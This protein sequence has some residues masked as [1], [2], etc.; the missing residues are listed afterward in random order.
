MTTPPQEHY[1]C[2][3]CRKALLN[4]DGLLVRLNGW[5]HAPLFSCKTSFA[6]P[7][8]PGE[9]GSII[10]EGV[11]LREGARVEFE[12]PHADCR[13]GFASKQHGDLAAIS[14]L[15]GEHEFT[16]LFNKVHG[17]QST[18]V[19]NQHDKVL[20]S[21]GEHINL[22]LPILRTYSPPTEETKPLE[23]V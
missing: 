18:F 10:G 11:Q 20:E 14:L 2:P 5:L 16:L 1:V 22:Y 13:H 3:F 7:A 9:Y 15:R 8:T 12:C 23:T 4:E 6:L 21:Y 17:C 19:L